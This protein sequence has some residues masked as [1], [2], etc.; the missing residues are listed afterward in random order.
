MA[1]A[2]APQ[3]QPQGFP[4]AVKVARVDVG[5]EPTDIIASKY[6]DGL[7]LVV[8]QIGAFGTVLR[9]RPDASAEGRTTYSTSVLLGRRDEPLLTL[10]AR[11]LVEAA[12]EGGYTR[13]LTVTLGLKHHT[14]EAVKQ[15]VAAVKEQGLLR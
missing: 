14:L 5:G 1:T 7:L 12:V 15:L 4:V 2:G 6:E 10:A 3:V 9:A 13:P 8:S 11:Q